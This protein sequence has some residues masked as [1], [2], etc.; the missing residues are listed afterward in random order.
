MVQ[1]E[2]VVLPDPSP[3]SGRAGEVLTLRSHDTGL[4]VLVD[5]L[6][7]LMELVVVRSSVVGMERGDSV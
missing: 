5:V 4:D 7:M 3:L 6:V 2:K 1:P